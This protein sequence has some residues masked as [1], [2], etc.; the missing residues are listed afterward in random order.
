M[1]DA[2]EDR[3]HADDHERRRLRGEAGQVVEEPP[4][5]RSQHAPGH[6]P[7]SEDA[8]RR[9]RPHREHPRKDAQQRQGDDQPEGEVHHL[10]GGEGALHPPVPDVDGFRGE[11]RDA[12]DEHAADGRLH[13]ARAGKSR[14]EHLRA[15]QPA[16]VED[17]EQPAG[18]AQGEVVR[19]L[20]RV[21]EGESRRTAEDRRVVVP[22]AV[23]G[24][25][26]D[27][28]D[29]REQDRVRLE[30]VAVEGLGG[31][32][33]AAQGSAEDGAH[34]R[35]HAGHQRP[36]ALDRVQPQ[37]VGYHRA[38]ASRDL[39]RRPLPPGSAT[40]A[41]RD[42]GGDQ[43][44]RN[45]AQAHAPAT[46]VEGV[47]HLVGP[48]PL[49]LRRQRIDEDPRSERPQS[50]HDREHPDA[51][52]AGGF[53]AAL[54]QGMG[55]RVARQLGEDVAGGEVD[56]L[57]EEDRGHPGHHP[58]EPS[59]PER[60]HDILGRYAPEAAKKAATGPPSPAT[61]PRAP[62]PHA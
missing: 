16:R 46:L 57:E 51:R 22:G 14:E 58:D 61:L 33:R 44:H 19:Q 29:E 20:L 5:E 11:H 26:Y 3:D 36:P 27:R 12:T 41:D 17:A 34:T 32:H 54:A 2:P 23:D 31:H 45:D 13:P 30:V 60:A 1:G 48:G 52:R 28:G 8:S 6:H 59:Q 4:E 21:G 39:R 35:P 49:R 25:G 55:R 15:L 37:K 24:E 7:G 9:T 62:H 56:R 10:V 42:G 47:D 18:H 40:A 50:H 43:L 38:D 53:A